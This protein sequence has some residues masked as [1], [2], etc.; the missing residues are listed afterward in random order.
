M[1]HIAR[2]I[3]HIYIHINVYILNYSKVYK[4]VKI[5]TV[6]NSSNINPET[7]YNKTLTGNILL[8]SDYFYFSFCYLHFA[9][10]T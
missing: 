7:S 3:Y 5:S 9:D 1:S 8:H 2:Y 4:G 10:N 6:L